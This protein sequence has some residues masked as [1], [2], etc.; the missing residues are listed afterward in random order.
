MKRCF[1]LLSFVLGTLL[2]LAQQPNLLR[3]AQ[4][5]GFEGH[6]VDLSNGSTMV[7][8]NDTSSGNSDI[9]AQKVSSL[10]NV[11]WASARPMV[12]KPY[13]QRIL[14]TSVSSDGNV[15][16]M[17]YEYD[18]D[19]QTL[20]YWVQKISQAGQTLWPNGGFHVL[21]GQS[22]HD[23]IQLVP[24]SIGGAYVVWRDEYPGINVQGVNL[25]A[26]GIN[27][28]TA[29][30]ILSNNGLYGIQ[31]V[32]DGSGGFILNSWIYTSGV[33]T[34]NLLLRFDAAGDIVGPNPLLPP[35]ALVPNN[36]SM[37]K[38]SL[39]N[40]VLYTNENDSLKLQKIDLNGTILFPSV[41]SYP[42]SNWV[43]IS[44]S[45]IKAGPEGSLVYAYSYYTDPDIH[46]ISV[47]Y[48]NPNGQPV[49]NNPLDFVAEGCNSLSLETGEGFWLSWIRSS[50][51]WSYDQVFTT[52]VNLDGSLAFP[53]VAISNDG[54]DKQ[55][56]VITTY[57]N[58]AVVCWNDQ[59]GDHNG[60]R[61]QGISNAG[62]ILQEPEGKV[63]YNVLNGSTELVKSLSLGN[64]FIHFYNDSRKNWTNKL[65]Y[66]I[67]DSN[68]SP[69]LEAN[70]RALNPSSDSFERLLDCAVTPSNTVSL[71]YALYFE[72]EYYLYLQEITADGST[73]YVGL[74]MAVAHGSINLEGCKLSIVNG[75]VIVVWPELEMGSA[76]YSIWGQKYS[77]GMVQWQVDGKILVHANGN[78]L[79][80]KALNGDYLLYYKEDYNTGNV[81]ILVQRIAP[82]GDTLTGWPE[83]GLQV[84]S[85]NNYYVL[86][87]DSG[88]I[89]NNLVVTAMRYGDSGMMTSSQMIS[90][91]ATLL[92]GPDGIV[93]SGESW[94]YFLELKDAVYDD[95]LAFL[96][97][98][99]TTNELTLHRINLDGTQPWGE[100]GIP[101]PLAP[102]WNHSSSL[103]KYPNGT[104]SVFHANFTDNQGSQ[105]CRTDIADNGT[106]L[107]VEPLVLAAN[108]T[109]FWALTAVSNQYE[110]LIS[111][112]D[113]NL[114]DL[115]K[116]GEAISLNSLWTLRINAPVSSEDHVITPLLCKLGNHPNPFVGSTTI[117]YSLKDA[118]PVQVGIYNLK[119]QLVRTLVNETKARGDYC[120]DWD[121]RDNNGLPV[122]AGIYLYKIQAGKFSSS[123]KMVLL[124]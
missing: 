40:I 104:Y 70:G 93:L 114:Y 14:D 97:W 37:V 3:N 66:Q 80:P 45:N 64:N 107:Q 16:I 61:T 123:K 36:F 77:N 2:L 100:A 8:W 53:P 112:N 42:L 75:D 101:I 62:S 121:S 111:W 72:D 5:L 13:D 116:K 69:L 84:F 25:D 26:T 17:Y 38:D 102:G 18:Y 39:G 108:Q 49:W 35:D 27:L 29:D 95:G 50:G 51:Y 43:Y 88:I 21:C 7:F 4:Y 96:L 89:D 86:Y 65:Y 58:R 73:T 99:D 19:A 6:K 78:Y 28:W 31:A 47:N 55:L 74:G 9:M 82:N 44:E 20:S 24:N 115:S 71:F 113:N 54:S 83:N 48:L 85:D 68:G 46:R 110:A 76:Y 119:G 1:L 59:S 98:K 10:G 87:Q 60:I 41:L 91:F 106:L 120:L 90:P 117:S 57:N 34:S 23:G 33:G 67:T 32:S 118:S 105:L 122:A 15:L 81:S 56:P 30:P 92:W 11:L 63:V 109:G 79:L 22:Y 103:L 124:K 94:E 52:L 12:V